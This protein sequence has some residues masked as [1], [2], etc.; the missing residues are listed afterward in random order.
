MDVVDV[1]VEK[2]SDVVMD[3]AVL[4]VVLACGRGVVLEEEAVL[5]DAIIT[6][7]A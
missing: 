3:A 5:S 1:T 4:A 6:V 2:I 7:L